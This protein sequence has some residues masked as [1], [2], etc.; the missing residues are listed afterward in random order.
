VKLQAALV[1]MG[2]FGSREVVVG[3][4]THA[5]VVPLAA[6]LTHRGE[7][8]GLAERAIAALGKVDIFINKALR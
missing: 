7:V 4:K 1:A 2:Q 8:K 6:D 5:K 3:Q